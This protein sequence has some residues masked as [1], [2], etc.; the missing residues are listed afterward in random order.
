MPRH[1]DNIVVSCTRDGYETSNEVLIASF[2]GATF[3]NLLVGGFVGVVIDASS[4]A[5]NKYPEQ[6][7]IV[8]TPSIFSDAVARDAYYDGVKSR[9]SATADAE[10]RRITTNCSSTGK[11]LCQ[12]EARQIGEARDQA[13]AGIDSK[14]LAARIG[15]GASAATA[16]TE[17]RRPAESEARARAVVAA[18]PVATAATTTAAAPAGP[19]DGNYSGPFV[20]VGGQ[21]SFGAAFGRSVSVRVL[22][23]NGTGTLNTPHCGSAPVSLTISPAGDITGQVSGFDLE[24]SRLSQSIQGRATGGQLEITFE[25]IP[26]ARGRATLTR[27]VAGQ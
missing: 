4:G 18:P 5:N 27:G 23:G 11:E 26:A 19:F 1:K 21:A 17:P 9:L 13:L 7:V 24:C 3:G 6:V 8:M 20:F 12:I 16:V 22:D 25:G 10:I 14:R 2:T 15:P